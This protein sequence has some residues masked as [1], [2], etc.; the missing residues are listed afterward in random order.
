MKIEQATWIQTNGW[1]PPHLGALSDSAQL[2]MA[3]GSTAVLKGQNGLDQ[4]KQA[5]PKAHLLGCSTAGEI[6]TACP[7]QPLDLSRRQCGCPPG[8]RSMLAADP[9]ERL[10]DR[11]M[12]GVE[13]MAGNAGHLPPLLV[14]PDGTNELLDV[15]P[16]PPLGI[17]YGEVESRQF[18]IEDGSLFVLYTDGLVENKG[19]DISDGL[20]RLRGIFGPGSPTRP[21][22]DL[23]KATLDGV[24]SDEQRDDIAV[25]IAR[26][27][28]LPEENY[29]SWTYSPKLTSVR[30][31]RAVLSSARCGKTPG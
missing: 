6:A 29:A 10:A 26:L 16:A 18:K 17:G 23:C 5:W 31:A 4:I 2:V 7:A 28:R 8:W 20:A 27:R 15:P 30:E 11:R 3:F 22:E 12:L 9:A 24:Y 14:R 13:G 1:A 25:L 21:L 19:Q